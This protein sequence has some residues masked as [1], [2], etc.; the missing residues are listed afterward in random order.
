M[1]RHHPSMSYVPTG[2]HGKPARAARPRR[3][4]PTA[5]VANVADDNRGAFRSGTTTPPSE[6]GPTVPRSHSWP[7]APSRTRDRRAPS[8]AAEAGVAR[9]RLGHARMVRPVTSRGPA[10]EP[11][12][13]T[14]GLLLA[15]QPEERREPTLRGVADQAHRG[16]VVAHVLLGSLLHS[17][18]PRPGLDLTDPE[19][20]RRLTLNP[21]VAS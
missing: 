5:P 12:Q 4:Q 7:V 8:L 10:A 18:R 3:R 14:T 11:W 1:S 21:G 19:R 2:L 17:T 20:S 9:S 13:A 16:G 6:T 15:E